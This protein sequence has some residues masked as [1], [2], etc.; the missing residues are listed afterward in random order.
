MSVAKHLVPLVKTSLP[1]FT[2]GNQGLLVSFG[3]VF[4][5]ENT[6]KKQSTSEAAVQ[7]GGRHSAWMLHLRPKTRVAAQSASFI[8]FLSLFC[9]RKALKGREGK[10]DARPEAGARVK[11]MDRTQGVRVFEEDC[12]CC[13]KEPPFTSTR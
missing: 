2:S 3:A 5:S 6:G 13:C 8:S 10:R 11:T 9:A 7:S 4:V 1:H 12:I